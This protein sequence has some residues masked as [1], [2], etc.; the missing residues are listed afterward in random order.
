MYKLA[1]ARGLQYVHV[2]CTGFASQRVCKKVSAWA[3][4]EGVGNGE[5]LLELQKHHWTIPTS[6]TDLNFLHLQSIEVEYFW[7]CFTFGPSQNS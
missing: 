7:T 4:E 1:T 2:L 5:S 6:A 3:E